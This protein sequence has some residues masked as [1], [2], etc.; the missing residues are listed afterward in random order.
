MSDSTSELE[1]ALPERSP[2][3]T[4]EGMPRPRRI[5]QQGVDP[6][7][8]ANDPPFGK[9]TACAIYHRV[10]T[11]DQD[12]ELARAELRQAAAARGLSVAMEVEETGSGANNSRP[13]LQQVLAAARR[14]QVSAVLVW[15]LDRFGRSAL[16]VLANIQSLADAGVRFVCTSQGIDIKA[17][18]DAMSRLMLTVL[19]AVA[20]FERD[21][22]RERTRLGMAA[23]RAAG[24]R[25][26]RPRANGPHPEQVRCLRKAG[27]SWATIGREL[28]CTPSM[29]VRRYAEAA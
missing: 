26:G 11:V 21:L 10:S 5:P 12:P 4:L 15:K 24:R 23:A 7:R 27:A 18:G 14:G 25:V 16:D 28:G 29:A 22:I 9:G 3:D 8:K 19:A 20:E 13:G 6:H 17:E 1:S 2:F